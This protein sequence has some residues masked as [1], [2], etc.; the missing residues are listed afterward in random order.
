MKSPN[1]E[2][3]E[4]VSPPRSARIA[5]DRPGLAS[6]AIGGVEIAKD[7]TEAQLT[8][9]GTS[10]PRL[11]LSLD[12][13]DGE[14]DGEVE[15][16]LPQGLVKVLHALGWTPPRSEAPA[17]VF[18]ILDA[19]KAGAPLHFHGHTPPAD[20]QRWCAANLESVPVDE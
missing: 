1:E 8:L 12:L 11:Q 7:V 20:V 2:T 15:A 16:E 4:A 9:N 19:L 18:D 3:R 6:I 17:W 13:F 10:F 5:W 14:V